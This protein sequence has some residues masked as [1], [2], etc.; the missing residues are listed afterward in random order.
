MTRLGKGS[1]GK[2]P[3]SELEP[4]EPSLCWYSLINTAGG[5]AASPASHTLHKRQSKQEFTQRVGI[6]LPHLRAETLE[7][8]TT[9]NL[10]RGDTVIT[11][12]RL[13]GKVISARGVFSQGSATLLRTLPVYF[14]N[15]A[16]CIVP[17]KTCR[18]VTPA[19]PVD[20]AQRI[21]KMFILW[22]FPPESSPDSWIIWIFFLHAGCNPRQTF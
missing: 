7:L 8:T 15:P 22:C 4:A 21:T 14:K 5:G 19:L 9:F 2:K 13:P 12:A 10:G 20:W 1:H 18:S 16:G 11:R 3:L 6:V 17:V